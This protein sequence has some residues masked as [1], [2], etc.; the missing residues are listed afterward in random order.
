CVDSAIRSPW[1]IGGENL[2]FR[3]P[4]IAAVM[5]TVVPAVSSVTRSDI[6]PAAIAPRGITSTA[7]LRASYTRAHGIRCRLPGF[8]PAQPGIHGRDR[9][10]GPSG[11]AEYAGNRNAHAAG[12]AVGREIPPGPRLDGVP[13]DQAATAEG[14]E[15]RARSD[16]VPDRDLV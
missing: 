8:A 2:M 1:P 16:R 6:R 9:A 10:A 15:P 11:C 3:F 7:G 14:G 12:A 5:V 4:F 13:R